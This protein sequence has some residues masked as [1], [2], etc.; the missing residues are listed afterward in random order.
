MR[1][2]AAVPAIGLLTGAALGLLASDIPLLIAHATMLA[3]AGI[4][5]LAWRTARPSVLTIAVALAFCAGGVALSASAWQK[6]RRP[7]LRVVFV[8]REIEDYSHAEIAQLLDITVNASE[9]RLH[10]ALRALRRM[11]TEP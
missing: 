4:A 5:L 7:S 11:L 1:A 9:V 8:L 10:R 6:A 3:C 2:A